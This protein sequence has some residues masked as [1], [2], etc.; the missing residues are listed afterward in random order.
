MV[1]G[2]GTP[3]SAAI[4]TVPLGHEAAADRTDF[5]ARRV[6]DVDAEFFAL[7]YSDPQPLQDEFEA[8]VEAAWSGSPPP[9]PA[10]CRDAEHPPGHGVPDPPA[11]SGPVRPHLATGFR[12]R[13]A[14]TRSPPTI[15]RRWP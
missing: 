11:A 12:D 1:T 8:I 15:P 3:P 7:V 13:G 10:P 5:D 4:S 2:T 14:R 9:D 6:A